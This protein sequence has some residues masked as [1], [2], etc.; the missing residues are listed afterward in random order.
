M[1][2]KLVF[3]HGWS[4][5]SAM[6]GPLISKL[7][8]YECHTI[9]LGFIAGGKTTWPDVTE[10]AI[11][12]GHSLGVLWLLNEWKKRDVSPKPEALISISGFTNFTKFTDP[13][14]LAFM[15]RSL[16]KKPET[17]LNQFWQQAGVEQSLQDELSRKTFDKQQLSQGLTWLATLDGAV[18]FKNLSCPKLILASKA[19]QIVPEEGSAG[20]W[21]EETIIW[22][23]TAP[24]ML[25]LADP[26]W[27]AVKIEGFMENM[28]QI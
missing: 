3:I 17:Q 27:L 20:Q 19:D 5:N 26:D 28:A 18:Q 24:H 9:D 21:P 10:P 12:I 13:R 4:F 11:Y 14:V 25:P 15:Q 22:H 7:N 1:S 16:K 6:W 8:G 23:E 2:P